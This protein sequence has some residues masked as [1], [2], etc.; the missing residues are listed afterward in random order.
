MSGYLLFG[1][2]AL[3]GIVIIMMLAKRVGR[4]Q[5]IERNVKRSEELLNEKR[6]TRDRL[7]DDDYIKRVRDKFNDR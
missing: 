5:E 6:K 2:M 7:N 1:A 3:A 4:M